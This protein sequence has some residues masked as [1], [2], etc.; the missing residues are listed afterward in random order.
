MFN[1]KRRPLPL[2]KEARGKMIRNP[3][4]GEILTLGD[5]PPAGTKRWVVS[6]K[7]IV[8][9]AVRGELLTLED[10]CERY[11][12]SESEFQTWIALID[13]HGFQGLRVTKTQEYRDPPAVAEKSSS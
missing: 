1:V 7:A 12:L 3:I 4:N 10:A 2:P 8:V 6:R 11:H 9:A 5:L 13:K